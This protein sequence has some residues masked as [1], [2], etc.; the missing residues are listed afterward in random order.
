MPKISIVI[1]CYYNYYNIPETA[2]A[3]IENEALFDSDAVFEYILIDDG[4]GDRTWEKLKDFKSEYSDKVTI[5]RL[6][7]NVGSYNAIYPGLQQANGNCIVIMAADLQD[8]PSHIKTMF[9]QWELGNKLILANRENP[10]IGTRVYFNFLR[11][12]GLPNLPIGGFDFCLFDRQLKD[13]MLESQAQGGNSLYELLTLG[14]N[15]TLVP[16]IKQERK[17]G[18]TRWTTWKKTK[19]ALNTINRYSNFRLIHVSV[20][21][22]MVCAFSLLLGVVLES[23]SSIQSLFFVLAFGSIIGAINIE[24]LR[25]VLRGGQQELTNVVAEVI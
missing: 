18:R 3:L 16:Y 23:R 13:K 12:F 24:V 11:T 10:T 9:D 2:K 20:F 5:I 15:P 22:F 1:P 14:E 6:S 19:L 7:R 17:I 8:P 21:L 4:S 25:S